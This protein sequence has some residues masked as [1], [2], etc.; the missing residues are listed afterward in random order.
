MAG[1]NYSSSPNLELVKTA[2]DELRDGSLLRRV[3]N[4]KASA[5][6]PVVFTQTSASNAAHVSTVIG[7][8]GYFKKT[9]TGVAQDVTAKKNAT[10]SAPAPKTTII[11]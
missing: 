4:G 7:S 11:A 9:I 1:L 2:L 8:G 6:D 10:K 5:D 3:S